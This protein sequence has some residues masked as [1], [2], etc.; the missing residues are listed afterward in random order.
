MSDKPRQSLVT[1]CQN[2]ATIVLLYQ[3][4]AM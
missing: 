1:A 2:H 4:K 3:R